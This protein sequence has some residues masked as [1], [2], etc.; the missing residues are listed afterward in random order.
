ML[1]SDP[2]RKTLL[3]I[4]AGFFCIILRIWQLGVL[5][6]EQKQIEA[7][8]PQSKIILTKANRGVICDR[9]EIPMAVNKICY[10]AVI[11]YGQFQQ[12]PVLRWEEDLLG[13][14]IRTWPRKEYIQKLSETLSKIISIPKERIEDLIYA[15]SSLF[16]HTPFVIKSNL[17]EEEHYQVKSLERNWLGVHAEIGSERYYPMGKTAC[18]IL[19]CMGAIG[20][21]EFQAFHE[22]IAI[23]KAGISLYEETGDIELP[24]GYRHLEEVYFRLKELQE[25]AYTLTDLIGKSGIEKECEEEL[26]GYVGQKHFEIDPK[27]K[28]VRELQGGKS[29]IHGH[30]V[31]LTISSELQEFA[32][33]LLVKSERDREGKSQLLDPETH[34]LKPQKQPWIKGGAIV[35][36]DPKTGEILALASAP[37]FDPNDFTSHHQGKVDRW[38]ENTTYKEKIWDG[39]SFLYRDA[40]RKKGF[41]EKLSLT[42][43]LHYLFPSDHP[44]LAFFQ[45]NPS[46]KS[47][48][49]LQ[50]A[51]AAVH[52]FA[53]GYKQISD[54][55]ATADIL[56]TDPEMELVR[57]KLIHQLKA[58]PSPE[59]RIFAIDLAKTMLDSSRFS[60]Q[61]IEQIGSISIDSYWNL[62]QEVAALTQRLKQEA[63]EK[64]HNT[65]FSEW[66]ALFQKSF[67][68]EKRKEEKERKTYA[69][70]YID[71]LD[72]KEKELFQE[73]WKEHRIDAIL[74]NIDQAPLLAGALHPIASEELRKE[75]IKTFRA[76]Q[77][78]FEP[79]WGTYK[80]LKTEK[81]LSLAFYPKGGFGCL[82]SYAFQA[83]AP[84]GSIF[85]LV[86]AYE[87]LRQSPPMTLIDESGPGI[88]HPI[89]ARSPQGKTY[90]RIY[91]GGRLPRSSISQMG[92]IDLIG[93]LEQS[94]NPYF[95][96]LAS[97]FMKSPNDLK[98][99]ARLFG[100][101]EKTGIDLPGEISGHLPQD[102]NFNQTGLYSFAIGQHTFLASPLQTAVML[103]TI[104]T[105][106]EVL[107]PKIILQSKG[108]NPMNNPLASLC[109]PKPF[110]EKELKKI[111][112]HFSLFTKME[113]EEASFANTKNKKTIKRKLP[114]SEESRSLIMEGMDHVL[115][116]PKGNAR[117]AIIR[118]LQANPL[119]KQEF[120][121][122]KHH[123]LGK[124]GTA[125]ILINPYLFP[126]SKPQMYKHCSFGAIHLKE[127][128]DGP[129]AYRYATPDLVVVVFLRYSDAGKEAAPLA[130][131]VIQKWKKIIE[132]HSKSIN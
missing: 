17:S 59:D 110:A 77:E 64:F 95:S 33:E 12:I 119:L 52:Y 79:L 73:H 81:D 53:S 128:L 31:T 21:K 66:R 57:K 22:E 100:Y 105:Q 32:E 37:R 6:K 61:L 20:A 90:P 131:Q 55:V 27:G 121:S 4:L 115:W 69:R 49:E 111:G 9:F 130:A 129:L 14:K 13:K 58:I 127:G 76:A 19:G 43:Y 70:P 25:K 42:S 84:L 48:I 72:Q 8:K 50:E 108:Q 51:F 74:K 104:A 35:A 29:P 75:F 15:K 82:R 120:L 125:Q 60:D 18:H 126:S 112:I 5:E 99:A 11:Y 80:H 30:K 1:F 87:G 65:Y 101:G 24:D 56:L 116:S 102:L 106:G 2:I 86:T 107:K 78:L 26:R 40:P 94:S 47:L 83:A 62:R 98:E 23:L 44:L 132:E 122:M 28:F 117:P 63:L 109:S 92:K 97:D 34:K 3:I 16:P 91:K 41:S 113:T 124:T 88:K 71:Y 103:T 10:N 118:G 39:E 36:M 54:L 7:Q 123:L 114:F 89:I 45:E 68:D 96:I 85:K 93:A 67:L 38:L 46:I